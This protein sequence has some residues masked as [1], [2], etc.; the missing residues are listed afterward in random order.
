MK[1]YKF[2]RKNENYNKSILSESELLVGNP[3]MGKSNVILYPF[4]HL[5]NE[6][7]ERTFNYTLE[8]GR[9]MML[10][11]MKKFSSLYIY[12]YDII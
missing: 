10:D 11:R 9:E 8:T 2:L 6:Y 7:Q 5:T 4:E 3:G 12:I 1:P